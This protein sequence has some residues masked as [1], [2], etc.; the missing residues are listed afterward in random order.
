MFENLSFTIKKQIAVDNTPALINPTNLQAVI[1]FIATRGH[2]CSNLNSLAEL[3][4]SEAYI[5]PIELA[6]QIATQ[7]LEIRNVCA[8]YMNCNSN[9]GPDI[10]DNTIVN[11]V[12]PA[13]PTEL[14]DNV[15]WSVNRHFAFVEAVVSDFNNPE[16]AAAELDAFRPMFDM[17]IDTIIQYSKIDGSGDWNY[18]SVEIKKNYNYDVINNQVNGQ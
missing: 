3:L 16:Q 9:V 14:K 18:Y 10:N 11:T 5:I 6:K 1:G 17:M 12:A 13:T 15:W 7:L 8:N 4:R 2:E